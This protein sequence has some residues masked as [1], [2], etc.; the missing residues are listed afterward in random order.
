MEGRF[1]LFP[2]QSGMNFITPIRI[3]IFFAASAGLG[4]GAWAQTPSPAGIDDSCQHA[5]TDSAMRNCENARYE[6]A[7][8]DLDLAYKNLLRHLDLVRKRKLQLA[9]AAWL[10]F[11]EAN[12]NFQASLNQG[13]TLAPLIRVACLSRMTRERASELKETTFP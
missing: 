10:R 8:H 11:R 7:Q 12:A 4:T 13:G 3:A 5:T 2:G 6:I 1:P 9:Q